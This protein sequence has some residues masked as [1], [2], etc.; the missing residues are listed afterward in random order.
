MIS[1]VLLITLVFYLGR[2]FFMG[3][4]V[5]F[6]NEQQPGKVE[7][8]Q[9]NLIPFL[10]FPNL[11]LQLEEVVFFEGADSVADLPILSLEKIH[12]TLH[13][14]KL[15]RGEVMVSEARLEQGRIR[16]EIYEDSVSN[17]E[18]ALGMRFGAES[19]KDSTG[20]GQA[21]Q[22]DLDAI[23][24]REVHLEMSNRPGDEHLKLQVHQLE[25]SFSYLPERIQAEIKLD[26]EI[27]QVKY[28]TINEDI[29]RNVLLNGSIVMHPL[30][31]E[32]EVKPSTLRV[33]GLDFETWGQYS[34][35]DVSSLDFSYRATNEGLELLNFLFRGI[36]DLDEVEQIGS[37]TMYLSGDVR[38]NLGEQLPVLSLQGE[39]SELGFRIKSLNKD[40]TGISF[41][42]SASNGSKLDLSE[43]HMDITGFRA[44]FPEGRIS[45]NAT[46]SNAVKPELN[47][48][49]DGQLDL[50]GIEKMLKVDALNRL[51]GKV[52]IGGKISGRIDRA[53]GEF[54]NDAG[55]IRASL[56]DVGLVLKKDSLRSDSIRNLD[57]T[58]FLSENRLG[59][60]QLSLEYNGNVIEL[61]LETENL[62][63]YL[64][65]YDTEVKA[66][67]SVRADE[68]SLAE[69]LQDTVISKLVGNELRK[70]HFG[71]SATIS[72][73]ELD[74]FLQQDSI[75]R[76]HMSVD[77]FGI[78]FASMADISDLQASL[79]LGPDTIQLHSLSGTLGNSSFDFSGQLSNYGLLGR[80]DTLGWMRFD[81]AMASGQMRAEDIFTLKQEFLLPEVYRTE[82]LE[83]FRIL[84]S[85]ELSS[86][87]LVQDSVP[88]D[89]SLDIEDLNWS[90]RYYPLSF[91]EFMV[92]LRRSG[93]QL[94][95]DQLEGQVGESNLNMSARINN[96][97]DSIEYMDGQ[98][99]L[100]SDLLDFNTLLNYQLPETL[101][102]T[103]DL[104]T[105]N[106]R[107]P[108]R[109]DQISYPSFDFTVD[110][111]EMRYGG[112]NIYGMNGRLR[113]TRDKIFYLDSLSIS[114]E[115]GG[116]AEFNGR[117]NASSPAMYS[118]GAELELRD[119]NINDIGVE[120]QTDSGSYALNENFQGSIS[121]KGLAEIFITPQL[122][123]DI[124][125][126]TAMFN[127]TVRDG[128][129]IDFTPLQAAGKFLDN[130]NLDHVRFSTLRNSFTLM[131][132]RIMIPRMNVE[133][134]VGQLLI[135]GEQGLDGSFLYL[136]RIPTKLVRQA[137]RSV[138]SEED[139]TEDSQEV[140]QMQRGDFMK[141]TVWSNGTE[142]DYKLGDKRDRF[143]E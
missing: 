114:S 71:A 49:V 47:I 15:I 29:N 135:E 129:L 85:L 10:N 2:N 111:G 51:E 88:L 106:L 109:L 28:L 4:A 48:E 6:L 63:L 100:E 18:Y 142:S 107:E 136:L 25:S 122:K 50:E 67:M 55:A 128:A 117:F 44:R 16:L 19:E 34:Y 30:A 133:S 39:A 36:L 75:P 92:R 82:Y 101:Q 37:G 17:L 86:E 64:L 138:L 119:M 93:D 140:M 62:L 27:N 130:K 12:V 84:G 58:V 80:E 97:T 102:D 38:G 61:G 120:L 40:V 141:V 72:S 98:L 126:T 45:A 77:S 32:V 26:V 76:I 81:F 70:L 31:R 68:I 69:I 54:L 79:S 53:R 11:T 143:A 105:T 1:L 3:K 7:M 43:G 96:F 99:V 132:S 24:V 52:H 56:E 125:T 139:G 20:N 124:P 95:I 23:E 14:L 65:N 115:G 134:T 57:G 89:F 59:A 74:K 33:Y 112:L 22:V 103:S 110:I 113:S 60:E 66:G 108:P 87:G 9:M 90:F 78:A 121:A 8:G 123:V 13:P 73:Q 46:V 131:D 118:L 137:A 83:D 41:Q 21:I 5:N 94:F 35:G 127:V 91:E 42:V 104:D 116:S